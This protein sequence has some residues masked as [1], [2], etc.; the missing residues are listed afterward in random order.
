MIKSHLKIFLSK[1]IDLLS[2]AS[3]QQLIFILLVIVLL[4][5]I[6]LGLLP[7]STSSLSLPIF[8]LA[9]AFS[10]CLC[11]LNQAV[12]RH[13]G[14]TF[15]TLFDCVLYWTN[16]AE[17]TLVTP[18]VFLKKKNQCTISFFSGLWNCLCILLFAHKSALMAPVVCYVNCAH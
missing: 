13:N 1:L 15:R 10:F 4:C 12:F 18:V 14:L 6:M 8:F 16:K 5:G 3:C 11:Y 7:P 2:F 17:D 9:R